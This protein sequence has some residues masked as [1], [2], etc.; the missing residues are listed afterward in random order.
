MILVIHPILALFAWWYSP[1]TESVSS[2]YSQDNT[3]IPPSTETTLAFIC[4]YTHMM[5]LKKYRLI[6]AW[7]YFLGT[8]PV[9]NTSNSPST[10]SVCSLY[11]NEYTSIIP[12]PVHNQN[13]V[14]TFMMILVTHLVQNQ[15]LAYTQMIVLVTHWVQNKYLVYYLII[16]LVTAP[17]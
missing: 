16:T 17:T 6:L 14:Y 10:E 9:Q 8:H 2:L 11:L 12:N 15:Y 3:N 7:W 13:P 5:I 1:S 4:I